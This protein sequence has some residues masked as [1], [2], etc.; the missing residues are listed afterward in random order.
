MIVI[1]IVLYFVIISVFTLA[2]RGIYGS[3]SDNRHDGR[4]QSYHVAGMVRELS[5]AWDENGNPEQLAAGLQELQMLLDTGSGMGFSNHVNFEVLSLLLM[6]AVIG[7]I[8]ITN[9]LL[10]RM[11][12]KSITTPLD[13]LV[14][15]VHQVRDGNLE[16]RI[17]YDGNDEFSSVCLDFNEMAGQLFDMVN[18]RQADEKNRR[19]LIAGISHDLRTPLA[20]IRNYVEGL[21]FGIASTP[22]MQ[23]K[24]LGIIKDK[25]S[26]LEHIINQLF[27]FSKLD[28]GEFPM[29]VEPKDIGKWLSDSIAAVSYEYER[30]QINLVENVRDTVV[31][32][33]AI[34]LRNV[35]TNIL[36]NSLKYG[37]K[38]HS[39]IKVV[40][41]SDNANVVITLT[42]NGLG[43]PGDTLHML[44]DVF[45]RGDKARN[46]T[47]QGSGLGLAISAKIVERMGGSISAANELEGGLSI[48]I[49]LP[50]LE[51]F[52]GGR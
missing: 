38:E 47:S 15:G 30:L 25:T 4:G 34:Q 11:V 46:N 36:E 9:S 37:N 35:L 8:F 51:K 13:T 17:K 2:F 5:Q 42:D 16:Y 28:I 33:D 12:F 41:R 40:C 39:V 32:I 52:E 18:A 10:T 45:Y 20:S 50:V 21:E 31:S 6:V 27:L 24:Y 7:V 26:D 49:T 22:Q 23:A 48:R 14:Y 43:V 19:E 44:F 3:W 29:Q 1:P